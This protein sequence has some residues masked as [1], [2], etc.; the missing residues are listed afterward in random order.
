MPQPQPKPH[1][2][3]R[4]RSATQSAGPGPMAAIA[5]LAWAGQHEQAVALA[6]EALAAPG[7]GAAQRIELLDH[8]AD[9]HLA[10]GD[11]RARPRRC[12]GHARSGPAGARPAL[13]A[14]ALCRL[15]AVQTRQGQYAAAAQSAQPGRGR[16]APRAP[17]RARRRWRCSA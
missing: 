13:Q 1:A 11:R 17:A 5:E 14:L 6:N 2:P 9:S 12:P 7:L 10:L 8:R 15:A 3:R 16:G 4:R